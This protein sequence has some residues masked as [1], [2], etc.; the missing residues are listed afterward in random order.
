MCVT[1]TGLCHYQTPLPPPPPPLRLKV[2]NIATMDVHSR[3]VVQTLI[4]GKIET[5][6]SFLWQSQLRPRW[7]D[8][9]DDCYLNICDAEFRFGVCACVCMC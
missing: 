2:M 8:S 1:N 6:E 5:E 3:D 4:N 7:T 9:E